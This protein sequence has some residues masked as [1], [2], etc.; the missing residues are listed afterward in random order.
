[1][2]R[3]ELPFALAHERLQKARP[4]CNPNVAFTCQ[5]LLLAKKMG[6]GATK[7]PMTMSETPR[8]CRVV[9]RHPKEPWLL[10]IS[11]KQ[12]SGATHFDPRFAWT[13]QLAEA[14]VLWIGADCAD[15]WAATIAVQRHLKWLQTFEGI[16]QELRVLRDGQETTWFW[17]MLGLS[18]VD[19]AEFAAVD[20]TLDADADVMLQQ[21]KLSCTIA[22]SESTGIMSAKV[23]A[24]GA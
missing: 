5:L 9:Q 14:C 3:Y 20:G 11:A 1:M 19:A 24:A 8:T 13:V 4:V 18:K 2:W 10:L 17:Q 16:Q 15:E 23:A 12:A 6:T 7:V 22:S 21:A